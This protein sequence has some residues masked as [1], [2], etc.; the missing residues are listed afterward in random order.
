MSELECKDSM[1]EHRDRGL[2]GGVGD[3][4]LDSVWFTVMEE[5]REVTRLFDR[6]FPLL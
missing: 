3:D 4:A 5:F 2:E 6:R 1:D